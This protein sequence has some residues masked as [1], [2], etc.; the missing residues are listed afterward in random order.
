MSSSKL[1]CLVF[2][3]AA[4]SVAMLIGACGTGTDESRERGSGTQ[5]GLGSVS[6]EVSTPALPNRQADSESAAASSAGMERDSG[7]ETTETGSP[8]SPLEP[9][10]RPSAIIRTDQGTGV[11]TGGGEINVT[12][13]PLPG[14]IAVLPSTPEAM[15]R[16]DSATH[17][18]Q[19][20]VASEPSPGPLSP[21]T[22]F[23]EEMPGVMTGFKIV[24]V[25]E[26]YTC[27]IADDDSLKCWGA[28]EHGIADPPPR[29]YVQVSVGDAVTCTFRASGNSTF[30]RCGPSLHACAVD[31][32][33]DVTCWGDTSL[34]QAEVPAGKYLSVSAGGAHSCGLR[35]DSTVACWGYNVV[36]QTDAP[37]GTFTSVSAG[38]AHSCATMEGGFIECW[39]GDA[40]SSTAGI[41]CRVDPK[42]IMRCDPHAS[43]QTGA[44]PEHVQ[45]PEGSFLAVAAGGSYNCAITAEES[46]HCWGDLPPELTVDPADRFLSVDVGA[47]GTC[48]LTGDGT[49]RCWGAVRHMS[50]GQYPTGRFRS[51]HAGVDH[52]CGITSD[53][54]LF[55]WGNNSFGQVAPIQGRHQ[56]VAVSLQFG[57]TIGEDGSLAC[58]PDFHSQATSFFDDYSLTGQ[59]LPPGYREGIATPSGEFIQVGAGYERIA[60]GVRIE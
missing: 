25:G 53:G 49:P 59:P 28:N 50:I 39:G 9:F 12:P 1:Y 4:L 23:P 54:P 41:G 32:D 58:W 18:P 47:S 29:T 35:T 42:G 36:G 3:L 37:A 40:S 52:G 20:T 2:I 14:T 38:G 33:G 31:T 5:D 13:T 10:S 21:G 6:S 57:C 22:A 26:G 8:D 48:A 16:A 43:V 34:G 45:S 56:A 46:L 7:K 60:N 55:C 44:V 17:E 30:T 11:T 27:A 19:V 15:P 24:S 51:I